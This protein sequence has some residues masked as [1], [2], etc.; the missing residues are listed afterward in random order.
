MIS[1]GSISG[2]GSISGGDG[3]ISGGSSISG[4]FPLVEQAAS[5]ASCR[6]ETTV[7]FCGGGSIG[8]VG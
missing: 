4:A 6:V 7:H 3:S 2:V 8:G 5:V 1:T